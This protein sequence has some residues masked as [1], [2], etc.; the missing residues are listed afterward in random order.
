MPQS[1]RKLA[2]SA[3][4]ASIAALLLIHVSIAAADDVDSTGTVQIDPEPPTADAPAS[5]GWT[6]FQASLWPPIQIFNADW[7]VSGARINFPYGKQARVTGLDFGLANQ[8]ETEMLGAQLGVVN[9][10]DG[11]TGGVQL[12]LGNSSDLG[13]RGGQLGFLNLA[14]EGP[15]RGVQLGFGNTSSGL[16]GLQLGAVNVNYGDSVGA[17]LGMF[18]VSGAHT[19][20]QLGVFNGAES[21]R[22]LQLGLLNRVVDGQLLSYLPVFNAGW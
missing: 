11:T 5:E 3:R 15:V 19:G 18:N 1:N 21:L 2:G 13:L 7:K 4:V 12:G 10:N 16:T 20:V 17:Q 14:Y 9:F 8:V 22:G 6:P